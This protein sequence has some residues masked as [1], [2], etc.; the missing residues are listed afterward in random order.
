LNAP[1]LRAVLLASVP[2]LLVARTAPAQMPELPLGKWWKRPRVVEF[3]KVSPDQQ[4]RLEDVFSKNRR[5]FV[6]LKAE[7]E[8][9]M[10]DVEE[11]M[12]KKDSDPKKVGAAVDAL[13]QARGRLGRSHTMMVL[14]MKAILTNEQWQRILDRREEWRG[15]RDGERRM[16]RRLIDGPPRDG[17]AKEPRQR[18][19]ALPSEDDKP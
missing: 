17:V 8:R 1:R 4:E 3:L 16:R 10:I 12:A 14:E 5:T 11:L 7:V 13:E 9:R 19:G 18:G 2:L 6:D 15:E